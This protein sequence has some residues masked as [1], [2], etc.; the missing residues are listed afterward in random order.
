V[1]LLR[2][3]FLVAATA[4]VVFD[5]AGITSFSEWMSA[6]GES[7]SAVLTVVGVTQL[8]YSRQRAY[9]WLDGALLVSLLFTQIFVF[10]QEQLLG[11]ISL[12]I[13]LV[14]WGLLRSAM[15]AE[16]LRTRTGARAD[17]I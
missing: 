8:P 14:Y 3:T 15:R 4:I 16:Q 2:A 1:F 5:G 9:R 10:E 17:A 6:L 13:T 7:V 12:G 11:T